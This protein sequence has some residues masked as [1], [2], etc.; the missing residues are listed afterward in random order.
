MNNLANIRSQ[1]SLTQNEL[2]KLLGKSQG[3]IGHYETGKQQIPVSVAMSLI[4]IARD[5]GVTLKLDDIYYTPTQSPKE[6]ADA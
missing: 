6:P 1:L 4:K 5:H 2:A 3:N